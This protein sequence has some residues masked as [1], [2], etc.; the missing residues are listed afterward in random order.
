SIPKTLSE[1]ERFDLERL[2]PS[3]R[4]RLVCS[5]SARAALNAARLSGIS[6]S[7]AIATPTMALGAPSDRIMISMAGVSVL[8]RPRMAIKETSTSPKLIRATLLESGGP[9]P[10]HHSRAAESNRDDAAFE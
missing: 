7:I 1:V 8:A 5:R 4:F 2:D 10:P 3:A 9:A 6:T